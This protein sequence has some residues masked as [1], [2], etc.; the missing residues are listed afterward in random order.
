MARNK[1]LNKYTNEELINA[2]TGRAS[3]QGIVIW[4]DA[5]D[6]SVSVN[7]VDPVPKATMLALIT[8]AFDW[9]EKYT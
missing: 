5:N 4:Q 8:H 6:R 7:A 3:F 9:V 1:E 2:L